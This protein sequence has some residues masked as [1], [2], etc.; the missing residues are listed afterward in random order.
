MSCFNQEKRLFGN[1]KNIFLIFSFFIFILLNSVFVM[2]D[3][4]DSGEK[5]I[6]SMRIINFD[7][8]IKLGDFSEFTYL[9]ESDSEI[10]EDVLLSFWIE[11]EGETVASGSDTIY[12]KREEKIETAKIFLPSIIESG[13][14]DL[15]L[16]LN[17]KD[18]EIRSHRTIEIK[19][20]GTS[21]IINP[22]DGKFRFYF[23]ISLIGLFILIL[24]FVI[25]IEKKKIKETLIKEQKFIKKHR[26]HALI[27]SLVLILGILFYF[28]DLYYYLPEIPVYFYFIFIGII[29]L[30]VILLVIPKFIQKRQ[31]KKE[32]QEKNIKTDDLKKEL[33]QKKEKIRK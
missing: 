2:S 18:Y 27:F 31:K 14:Y 17:Y 5:I 9:I 16:K 26:A 11:G 21:A 3:L 25:Y 20:K 1:L 32:S 10:V 7:S 6:L 29:I 24:A 12:I 30:L 28:F 23:M 22:G 13:V 19:V 33:W 15:N 8:P 4:T